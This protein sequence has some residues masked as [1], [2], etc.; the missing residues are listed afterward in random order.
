MAERNDIMAGFEFKPLELEGAFLV[1]S[2][3]AGDNR[4]GFT[5]TFEK[6]IFEQA[7]IK[8]NLNETFASRSAKNVVR[9]LHFQMNKPQAKLV[10][11]VSGRVWDVIVD[12]RPES[13]TFRK[14]TPSGHSLIS[15]CLHRLI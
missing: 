13:P 14:A 5:K 4:G 7:G 3:Y 12:I 2:F 8:F 11:V 1:S 10:S 6:D 9:G 15:I